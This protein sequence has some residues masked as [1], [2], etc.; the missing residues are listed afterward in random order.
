MAMGAMAMNWD[1]QAPWGFMPLRNDI[2]LADK[3]FHIAVGAFMSKRGR[4]VQYLDKSGKRQT[5]EWTK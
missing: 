3:A 5:I 2:P 4:E 1:P